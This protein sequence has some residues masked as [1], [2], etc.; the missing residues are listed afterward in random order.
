MKT[1]FHELKHEPKIRLLKTH[2]HTSERRG[3]EA[4]KKRQE[5]RGKGGLS[6]RE[7]E[8]V[9]ENRRH[10]TGKGGRR[11]NV[12]TETRKTEVVPQP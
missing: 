9:N 8:N 3:C 12:L 11:E 1:R 10:I 7:R 4:D 6:V 5:K 2:S